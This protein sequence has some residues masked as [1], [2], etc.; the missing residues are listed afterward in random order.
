MLVL[1]DKALAN[2]LSE[3]LLLRLHGRYQE[4]FKG[5]KNNPYTG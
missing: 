5:T 4:I 1:G 3:S 2:G